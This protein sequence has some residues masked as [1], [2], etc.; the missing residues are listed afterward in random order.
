MRIFA[1]ILLVAAFV[2]ATTPCHAENT[3]V[4][5]VAKPAASAPHFITRGTP[6]TLEQAAKLNQRIIVLGH[7]SLDAGGDGNDDEIPKADAV[8][9]GIIVIAVIGGLVYLAVLE[10]QQ[11]AKY[12]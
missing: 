4:L 12:F 6:L 2:A 9:V 11:T 8:F 7:V 10:S 1:M 3:V 5:P